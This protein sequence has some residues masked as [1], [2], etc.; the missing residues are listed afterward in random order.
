MA[1]APL[2]HCLQPY[3]EVAKRCYKEHPHFIHVDAVQA[4]GHRPID[5][6]YIDFMS[7]SAHKFNGPKGIGFLYARKDKQKF[8]SPVLYG[9][10]QEFGLRSGTEAVPLIIGLA[11]AV[12]QHSNP[13]PVNLGW[14]ED[15]LVNEC[16]AVING[17]SCHDDPWKRIINFQLDVHNDTMLRYLS[18][19]EIYLSAGSAC[20]ANSS[21]PSHVLKAMGLTDEQCNRSIRLSVDDGITTEEAD[22][23]INEINRIRKELAILSEF[24]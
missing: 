17:S 8:L 10:G 24:N 6:K 22:T 18:K 15:R 5:I 14:L 2:F 12:R 19:K 3:E 9:G 16:D 13:L 21:K 1:A 7:V 20:N 23:L 4:F 11:E